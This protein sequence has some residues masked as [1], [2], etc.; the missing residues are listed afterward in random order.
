MN[1][2]LIITADDYGLNPSCNNAI[3]NGVKAGII[4]SVHVMMNLVSRQELDAL[5]QVINASGN[6]CGIG[7]HLN[8]TW[9]PAMLQMPASFKHTYGIHPHDPAVAYYTY[10]GL[11]LYKH[12]ATS[13]PIMRAELLAQ[14]QSLVNYLGDAHKIDAIS[15]HQNIH[16]WS[17]SFLGIVN[18]MAK[19]AKIPVRSPLRWVTE[20]QVPRPPYYPYGKGKKGI[21]PLVAVGANKIGTAVSHP[22][23]GNL[24]LSSLKPKRLHAYNKSVYTHGSGY[25][26]RNATGHW[27]G[28]PSWKAMEWILKTLPN[29]NSNADGYTTELYMHLADSLIGRDHRWDYTQDKRLKEYLTISH[30]DF[31][32]AFHLL[33]NQLGIRHGSYRRVLRVV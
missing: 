31:I 14:F 5:R 21:G 20:E 25:T 17:P 27:F 26:P 23:T 30:P 28:Q 18:E 7:L 32:R 4:T 2:G 19:P 1:P 11:N 22:S 13:M 9:G 16:F 33:K 15:S 10:K 6:N 24:L 8:T 3:R 29:M 12:A